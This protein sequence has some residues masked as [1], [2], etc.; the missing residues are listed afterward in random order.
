MRRS[1]T[2]KKEVSIEVESWEKIEGMQREKGNSKMGGA[3]TWG[4][5]KE[6]Q[7]ILKNCFF[8]KKDSMRCVENTYVVSRCRRGEWYIWLCDVGKM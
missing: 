4:P 1:N 3:S 5:W 6:P 2:I 8:E 7:K